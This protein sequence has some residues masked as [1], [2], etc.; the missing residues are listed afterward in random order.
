MSTGYRGQPT[1]GQGDP[2][3]RSEGVDG[4]SDYSS[5]EARKEL[6]KD[7]LGEASGLWALCVKVLL[8]LL[9]HLL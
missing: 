1:D 9:H 4:N 5:Q 7:R 6:R 8:L 2:R 3:P